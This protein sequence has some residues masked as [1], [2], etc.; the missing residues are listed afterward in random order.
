M[1]DGRWEMGEGRWERGD[2]WRMS[3]RGTALAMAFRE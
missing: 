2:E 3:V 1:G